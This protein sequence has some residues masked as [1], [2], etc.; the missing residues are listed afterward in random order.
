MKKKNDFLHCA[1]IFDFVDFLNIY[2]TTH[3]AFMNKIFFKLSVI[4]SI[5]VVVFIVYYKLFSVSKL[6]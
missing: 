3:I 2:V 5:N 1:I 6:L 4:Y